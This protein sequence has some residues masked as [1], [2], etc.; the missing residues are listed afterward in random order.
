LILPHRFFACGVL[1]GVL[2]GAPFAAAQTPAPVP[3]TTLADAVRSA[4]RRS[5]H[6]TEIAGQQ[7]RAQAEQTAASALW[8]EPPSV[9]LAYRTD[10]LQSNAGSRETEVGVAV[11][12]WLPGQ[13]AARLASAQAEE[14]AADTAQAAGKLQVAGLVR[15]A[16]WNIARQQAEV[17]LAIEQ[18]QA[19]DA[20]ASDV[21]RRVAA[22]DLAR[23]DAL[24]ARA[25]RLAA[26]ASLSQARHALHAAVLQWSAL[27]GFAGA[28]EGLHAEQAPV[29]AAL[30]DA[31]PALRAARLGVEL[32]RR[33][34]DAVQASQRSAPELIARLRQDRSARGE[35]AANSIG[36]GLRIAL[37]TDDRNAPLQAAA[38]NEL[39]LAQAT[40]QQLKV[41]LQA[42]I[43]Q[44]RAAA[45]AAEQQLGHESE[46]SKLMRERAALIERSFRAGETPLPELL[47]A[48]SDAARAESDRHRQSAALGLARARLQQ[49]LGILP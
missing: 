20:L 41:Q 42:E 1:A 4:W 31:H 16:A 49:A 44:T 14:S 10:R 24:A 38:F 29:D 26:S 48:L 35:P 45:V 17:D 30:G 3:V 33:R 28:P 8:A 32:G 37:G 19:L 15:E 36:V 2:L 40:E 5:L 43:E 22:G 21:E 46:R 6:S 18:E 25:E 39:A 11:P 12:L 13:R 7:R 34:L 9:E 23:V 27:T 47:R